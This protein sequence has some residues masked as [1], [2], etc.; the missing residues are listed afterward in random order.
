MRAEMVEHGGFVWILPV[1]LSSDKILHIYLNKTVEPKTPATGFRAKIRPK[2]TH[3]PI[4]S[5][6][7]GLFIDGITTLTGMDLK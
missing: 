5:S 1:V 2:S 3:T 4:E 7:C 6:C